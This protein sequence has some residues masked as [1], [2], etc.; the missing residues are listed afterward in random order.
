MYRKGSYDEMFQKECQNF[1]FRKAYLDS[2][3]REHE[4]EILDALKHIINKMGIQDFAK[5]VGTHRESVS[6]ILNS[7]KI[8]TVE[9]LDTYLAPFGRKIVLKTQE[10][11]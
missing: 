11:A 9:T 10:V 7:D 6:R 2:L 4:M 1:E 5:L 3:I 8:P